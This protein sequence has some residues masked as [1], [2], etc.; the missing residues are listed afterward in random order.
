VTSPGAPESG[1]RRLNREWFQKLLTF[2][3]LIAVVSAGALAVFADVGEDV[4]EQ[5]TAQLDSAL[6]AWVIGHRS[7]LLYQIALVITWIGSPWVM[8][9]L[10]IGAG[11]WFYVRGGRKRAGVVIAAPAAGSLLSPIVKALFARSR[12]AGAVL[13]NEHTY[14]FPSGHAATSAAVVVTLC[15]VLAREG[16]ISWRTAI[17]VGG[18][19]PLVVGLTRLYLDVHW[20]TDVV[21]GWAVGLF[22]AAVSAALYEYLRKSAPAD[23]ANAR[24]Q[25]P[26]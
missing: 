20:T 25:S 5:S 21:G 6:R 2:W 15:Y 10:A 1:R 22:V 3:T 9:L 4:A 8:I 18:T 11:A 12:P 24:S 23:V 26:S 17:L 13:L 16:V 14:S 7:P 19:V